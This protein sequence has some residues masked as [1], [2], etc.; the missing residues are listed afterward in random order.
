VKLCPGAE[1]IVSL[2]GLPGLV[3][4]DR[5]I[6]GPCQGIVL[7]GEPNIR[8]TGDDRV[9]MP[10]DKGERSILNLERNH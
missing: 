10:F 7:L 5:V 3:I 9:T 1:L 4:P 8:R 6:V 2:P